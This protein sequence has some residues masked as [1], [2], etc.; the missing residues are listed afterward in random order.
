[1]PVFG[2]FILKIAYIYLSLRVKRG[3]LKK[4]VGIQEIAA[5]TLFPR[6]DRVVLAF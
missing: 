4:R 2:H 6:N 3:N 5:V 1:M